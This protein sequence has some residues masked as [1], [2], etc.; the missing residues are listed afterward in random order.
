LQSWRRRQFRLVGGNLI[1]FSDV[2]KK[3]I[4]TIDLRQALAIEDDDDTRAAAAAMLSPQSSST[5]STSRSSRFIDALDGYGVER[6]FRIIFPHDAEISFFTD[7]DE[8][9]AQWSVPRSFYDLVWILT[10]CSQ[11]RRSP[12]DHR[13]HP[14]KPHLGRA[15][16]RALPTSD[17][18]ATSCEGGSALRTASDAALSLLY[19]GPWDFEG[20]AVPLQTPFP[21][22]YA[23]H[24][25]CSRYLPTSSRMHMSPC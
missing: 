7:T 1:A 11:A 24:I 12:A 23:P 17:K 15:P 13:A 14:S 10:I 16:L 8:E 6:S 9:K 3:A 18:G 19:F 21:P 22:I 2:T 20:D 4:S 5:T 25:R